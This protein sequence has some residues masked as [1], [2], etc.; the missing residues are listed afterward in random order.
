[1]LWRVVLWR[2]V[3]WRVVAG[4]LV[5]SRAPPPWLAVVPVEPVDAPRLGAAG[6]AGAGCS[7]YVFAVV[8][9]PI[10]ASAARFLAFAFAVAARLAAAAV[11]FLRASL[12][13]F[14]FAS[15]AAEPR[16]AL[17]EAAC[18][19]GEELQVATAAAVCRDIAP[20]AFVAPFAEL[21]TPTA[22]APA[23]TAVV[24]MATL[25]RLSSDGGA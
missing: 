25:P 17:R 20:V 2:V 14:T 4:A 24:G 23:T 9:A 21:T 5:A 19:A 22:T 3:L 11:A 10:A 13:D 12:A 1:M 6:C 16:V 7:T 18:S 15:T 8:F